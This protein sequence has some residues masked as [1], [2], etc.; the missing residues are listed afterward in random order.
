MVEYQARAFLWLQ[1]VDRVFTDS[2]GVMALVLVVEGRGASLEVVVQVDHEGFD[3]ADLIAV[4]EATV[5]VRLEEA[6]F[7]VSANPEALVQERWLPASPQQS[8][9]RPG[10]GL[11]NR[12][13]QKVS[14]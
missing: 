14:K 12:R 4:V 11:A 1:G 8:C 3:A 7:P 2:L 9:R 10:R 13:H 5:V 6:A